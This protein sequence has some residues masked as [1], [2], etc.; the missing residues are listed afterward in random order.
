MPLITLVVFM[1]WISDMA[2]FSFNITGKESK[3]QDAISII[4]C[5]RNEH[6]FCLHLL[7]KKEKKMHYID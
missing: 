1:K 3:Y 5:K 6:D 7:K 2:C 4:A